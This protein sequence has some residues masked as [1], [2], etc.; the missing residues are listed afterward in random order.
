LK[1]VR[2]HCLILLW[3]LSNMCAKCT[4]SWP[5]VHGRSICD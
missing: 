4:K 5:S 3:T 1:W 2:N